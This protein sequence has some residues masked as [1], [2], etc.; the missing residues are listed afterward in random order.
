MKEKRKA[1]P[2]TILDPSGEIQIRAARSFKKTPKTKPVRLSREIRKKISAGDHPRL[3]FPFEKDCPV[4]SGDRIWITRLLWIEIT[5]VDRD[6]LERR[7]VADYI[8]H[9]E[10]PRLLRARAHA[11]DFDA[12]KDRL[13]GKVDRAKDVEAAEE[14]GYTTSTGSAMKGEPEAVPREYQEQLSEGR[15]RDHLAAWEEQRTTIEEAVAKLRENPEINNV[16]LGIF[17]RR[18]NRIEKQIRR[19]EANEAA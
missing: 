7:W 19:G 12:M 11:A 15:R 2:V 14:S 5:T 9:N 10:R 16:E 4:E 13:D 17:E 18:L 6:G 3:T 8:E 1:A